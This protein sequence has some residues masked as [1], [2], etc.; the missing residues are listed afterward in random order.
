M[1]VSFEDL[2]NDGLLAP[3][4]VALAESFRRLDRDVPDEVVLAAALT[5]EQ[6]SRGHVCLDLDSLPGISFQSAD[7]DATACSS[8]WSC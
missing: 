2:K 5:S 3:I 4:H 7:H 6:L 8:W 1:P